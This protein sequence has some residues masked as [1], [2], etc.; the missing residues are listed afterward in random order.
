MQ[1][2][3][4]DQFV[5]FIFPEDLQ[6]SIQF[7]EDVLGLELAQDQSDCRIYQVAGEA[8]LGVCSC[9]PGR[10]STPGS[11]VLTFVTPKVEEWYEYLT[12]QGSPDEGTTHRDHFSSYLQLLCVRPSWPHSGVSALP[13]SDVARP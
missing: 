6:A 9:R 4:L 5:V 13:R 7:Y 8:F 12:S 11:V 10:S 1:R 3:K 2:P